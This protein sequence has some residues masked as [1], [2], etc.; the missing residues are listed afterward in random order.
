MHQD[1][2]AF[3]DHLARQQGEAV[4]ADAAPSPLA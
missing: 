4:R 2:S 1:L 3:A